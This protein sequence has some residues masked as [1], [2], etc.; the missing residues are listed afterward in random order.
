MMDFK[1]YAKQQFEEWKTTGKCSD[2][3]R[4]N[5]LISAEKKY[6]DESNP[7]FFYGD[8]QSSIVLIH[9]NPKRAKNYD[10]ILCGDI[11]FEEF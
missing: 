3:V 4:L 7:S 11:S 6:F 10:E 2:A 1:E 5:K 8:I 9:H